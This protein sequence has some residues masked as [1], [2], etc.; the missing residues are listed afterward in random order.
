MIRRPPR[1]TLFPYTTLFRSIR[2]VPLG[3]VLRAFDQ[4]GES[5]LRRRIAARAQAV[6]VERFFLG[7][8][9]GLGRGGFGLSDLAVIA[10]RHVSDQGPDDD[11]D[12]QQL[13]RGE[14]MG[15]R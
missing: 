2:A 8:Y 11:R 6:L 14:A 13:H 5:Q 4:R 15:A 12:H 9:L 10:W 7:V 3:L 1:S